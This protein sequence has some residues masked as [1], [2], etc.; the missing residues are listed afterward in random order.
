MTVTAEH[1]SDAVDEA[2]VTL[3]HTASSPD[4]GA[5]DGLSAADVT[6]TVTDDD[7][8]MEYSLVDAGPF[9]EDAGTVQVEVVAVTNEDGAPSIDYA[10]RVRSQNVTANSPGDYQAV[11]ETLMF[12]VAGFAAFTDG[13]GETRY[14]QTVYFEVVIADNFYD[15]DAETFLLNLSESPGYEGSVFGVAQTEVTIND[16]DT[17]GPDAALWAS[18]M[19]LRM[20]RP[21]PATPISR[22]RSSPSGCENSRN[23]CGSRSA[24]KPT[25]SSATEKATWTPCNTMVTRMGDSASECLA[26]LES[27]LFSTWIMRRFVSPP[28]MAG[29]WNPA[30]SCSN[31]SLLLDTARPP[32]DSG[33]PCLRRFQGGARW[34]SVER[35]SPERHLFDPVLASRLLRTHR[36]GWSDGLYRRC[37]CLLGSR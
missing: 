25:P 22:P 23:R 10:V 4:D 1:D 33:L 15:E 35:S 5:Y 31:V 2:Q 37:S 32:L 14:R 7:P 17:A 13:A 16:N 12:S 36:S 3:T 20:A 26:A 21:R 28:A 8:Q 19:P 6:V 18:T 27:R 34:L 24:G 30:N 9:D 11:D 29:D